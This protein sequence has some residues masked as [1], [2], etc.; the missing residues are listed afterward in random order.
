M[1]SCAV[2]QSHFVNRVSRIPVV[3]ALVNYSTGRYQEVLTKY[4]KVG[5]VAVRVDASVNKVVALTHPVLCTLRTPIVVA[6]DLACKTL[7][8]VEYRV[9]YILKTPQEISE[10]AKRIYTSTVT[11]RL[12]RVV[13]MKNRGY[14]LIV[15]VKSH[16]EVHSKWV[17]Q[18][19]YGQDVV[20]LAD[21]LLHAVGEYC[22][23]RNKGEKYPSQ[24]VSS[25]G[26]D[27]RSEKL[28]LVFL[29]IQYTSRVA[30]NG[31]F[32]YTTTKVLAL[33][34]DLRLSVTNAYSYSS[35]KVV[36]LKTSGQDSIA[37][38]HARILLIAQ[39]L[40][41]RMA[42]LWQ[43]LQGKQLAMHVERLR[44]RV[45]ALL[46]RVM[47]VFLKS[48]VDHP[49]S[50]AIAVRVAAFLNRVN[51]ALMQIDVPATF[52]V[53]GAIV[54]TQVEKL[55]VFLRM[56]SYRKPVAVTNGT[57]PDT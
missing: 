48:G 5:A 26:A 32:G 57:Q 45:V 25:L 23:K 35:L 6:D 47:Q 50:S 34:N 43:P 3:S 49:E 41:Q 22:D 12:E 8:Y 53:V 37:V 10:D 4:P 18:T 11:P 19:K 56:L 15:S 14:G 31:Q 33:P 52:A 1:G 13:A 20:R 28:K 30:W 51:E 27:Q 54:S 2:E 40:K 46:Q 42:V 17:L 39:N 36:S 16:G 55:D 29:K 38:V 9:P 44:D 21:G 7:D 24:A